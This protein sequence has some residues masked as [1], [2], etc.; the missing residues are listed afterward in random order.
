M[1]E[2]NGI[3]LRA[4][5]MVDLSRY[6]IADLSGPEGVEFARRSR[7]QFVETGLCMLPGFIRPGALELLSNEANGVSD[8]A[9]YC[10]SSHNPYLQLDDDTLPKD[11]PRR[12]EE[13]TFVGSVAYDQI[14]EDTALRT[15]YGWDPVEGLHRRSDGQA[16]AP[17]PCRPV[18]RLFDQ[19]LLRWRRTWLAF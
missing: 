13:H 5:D 17:P 10:K 15:I 2:Q 18:R 12:R 7:A 1:V 4:E 16:G 8:R 9:Y 3:G 6:P 14:P 11:H 19:C